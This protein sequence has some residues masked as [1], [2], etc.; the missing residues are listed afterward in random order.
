MFQWLFGKRKPKPQVLKATVES[1]KGSHG[2]LTPD[3]GTEKIFVHK[4]KL[5]AGVSHLEKGQRVKVNASSGEKGLRA[6]TLTLL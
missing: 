3:K 4:S 1:W 6:D 5:P 2:F